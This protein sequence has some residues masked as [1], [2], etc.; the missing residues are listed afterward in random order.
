MSRV[1]VSEAKWRIYAPV[2]KTI[3]LVQKMAWIK[4]LSETNAGLL[5]VL[6]LGANFSQILFE[7]QT[8][9]FK[10]MHY[11]MSSAKWQTFYSNYVL[12]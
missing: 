10:K 4:P 8:F 12:V 2:N 5:S 9:A 6:P 11:K 3:I 7:I 1:S